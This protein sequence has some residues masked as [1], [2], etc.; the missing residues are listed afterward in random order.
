[1]RE[2][3]WSSDVCSSDLVDY[4]SC[5]P[6][7]IPIVKLVAAQIAIQEKANAVLS[8]QFFPINS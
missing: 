7:R 2:S 6:F 4:V 3:D 5:S 8:E 1:M